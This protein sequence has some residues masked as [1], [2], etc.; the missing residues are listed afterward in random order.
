MA[1]VLLPP[2]FHNSFWSNQ[3]FFRTGLEVL[4]R[5]LQEGCDENVEIAVFIKAQAQHYR[6]LA[7]SIVNDTPPLPH[8][9]PSSPNDTPSTLQTTLA[10]IQSSSVTAQADHYARL[11]DDLEFRVAR[12]FE[13]WSAAHRNRVMMASEEALGH[14]VIG[15]GRKDGESGLVGRFEAMGLQVAKFK[16]N[17]L[18]KARLADDLEEDARFAPHFSPQ[19]PPTPQKLTLSNLGTNAK[20]LT[21][22]LPSSPRLASLRERNKSSTTNGPTDTSTGL[23]RTG[24]VADRINEKL[25]AASALRRTPGSGSDS[26]S[27]LKGIGESVLSLADSKAIDTPTSGLP[28][29]SRTGGGQAGPAAGGDY[30]LL[31]GLSMPIMKLFEFL[32]Q[33]Q[34]YLATS[35]PSPD[36]NATVEAKEGSASTAQKTS[37]EGSEN[38]KTGL[39]AA[40]AAGVDPNAEGDG[41]LRSRTRMTMLGSYDSCVSGAELRKW[42]LEHIEGL[43]NDPSRG[44]EAGAALV[45]WGLIGRIGVGRGWQDDEETFYHLKDAAFDTSPFAIESLK[46]HIRA[47]EPASKT[48]AAAAALENNTPP[49][50][51]VSTL[52][53][54]STA[55]TLVKSYLPAL[56]SLPSGLG[57]IAENGTDAPHVRAR[58]EAKL[59]DDEYRSGVNELEVMRLR[60]EEWMEKAL[61]SWERW[62]RERI[63]SVKT[64]LGQYQSVISTLPGRMQSWTSEIKIAIE[65]FKPDVE[66]TPHIY[67]SLDSDEPE[68]SFGIDLRKWAGSNWKAILRDSGNEKTNGVGKG[69]VPPAFV[70]LLKGLEMKYSEVPDELQRKSWIF[71]VDLRET[72][73]LRERINDP[74]VPLADMLDEV[75][76]FNAPVIAATIKLWLLELNPPV[77]GYDAYEA[78]KTLYAKRN[79][80]QSNERLTSAISDIMSRLSGVQILILDTL[81]AHL[82]ALVQNTRTEEADEVFI[83]KLA[84]SLGRAILRP[85]TESAVTLQDR[86]PSRL[87]TDL[88]THRQAIFAPLVERAQQAIDRPMPVRKRTRPVDQRISRSRLS[89]SGEDGV[90]LYR[91][92]QGVSS[93]P[94]DPA[95]ESV[96]PAKEQDM[97][98]EQGTVPQIVPDQEA[99]HVK[100]PSQSDAENVSPTDDV[101]EGYTDARS[102]DET[103]PTAANPSSPPFSNTANHASAIAPPKPTAA[104]AQMEPERPTTPPFR[105]EA[106]VDD[107]DAPLTPVANT[108]GSRLSRSSGRMSMHREKTGE[109]GVLADAVGEVSLKRAGSGEARTIRGPRGARGPRPGPGKMGSV[110]LSASPNVAGRP[111]SP[112]IKDRIA[113]LESRG[114]G[115]GAG[116]SSGGDRFV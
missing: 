24:T 73:E 100:A 23:R 46:N 2:T 65:A 34:H 33:L 20:N 74:H 109:V 35:L 88:Y 54:L 53:S 11:A 64:V 78:C 62:E 82:Q 83:T 69:N 22:V 76:K 31:A 57:S 52:P 89:E 92:L 104:A 12:D 47:S 40:G 112:S 84:L 70:A 86:T 50:P 71:L 59:A 21:P 8:I 48:S 116:A 4:M 19:A 51:A 17:Y 42:L 80:T 102:D 25:R 110:D 101:L 111:G 15:K 29:V 58:R 41:A 66:P 5:K 77:C 28:P 94:Q 56:S 13:R 113:H 72:H 79:D 32:A 67:E 81:F 61:K 96:P 105:R 90:K 49:A 36:V 30:I 108:A 60:V 26:I 45:K 63:G 103:T 14:G 55:S 39:L 10:T 85:A 107:K 37:T 106:T 44:S 87:F 18:T 6:Q 97:E 3:D 98:R 9:S 68:V 75:A 114:G 43:G 7:R 95:N 99:Q 115:G 93:V 91:N 27:S 16:Q 1:A 38:E